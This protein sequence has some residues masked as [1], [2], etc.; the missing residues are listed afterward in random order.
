MRNSKHQ[1]RI[2][3]LALEKTFYNHPSVSGLMTDP[4]SASNL[5]ADPDQG[6]GSR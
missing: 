3:L 1:A 5:K 6:V 4:V 2:S